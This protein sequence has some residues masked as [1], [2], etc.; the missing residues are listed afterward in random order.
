MTAIT[1]A[2]LI[3]SAAASIAGSAFGQSAK[4]TGG[5]EAEIYPTKPIRVVVPFG[6]GGTPD[7]L[8]RGIAEQLS[9][10]VGQPLIVDNRPGAGGNIGAGIVARANPDGYHL[11]MAP[12]SVLTINPSLYAQMPFDP[13]AAFAPISLVADMPNVLVVN[14]ANTAKS[15]RELIEAARR[16]PGTLFFSSPGQGTV[17][18]LAIELFQRAGGITVHHVPYKSGG[19]AVA[20]VLSGQVTGTFANLPLV[21]S[22]IRAGSL[23][24]LGIT[25]SSRLPQ[26]PDVPTISE[27]GVRGFEAS[28]WFGLVAPAKTPRALVDELSNQIAKALREPDVQARFAEIGV[29]LVGNSPEEFADYIRKDRAKWVE[30]IRSANVRLD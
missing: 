25:S 16:E 22:H 15:V 20:A 1:V 18:H 27:A 21:S 4:S 7:M 2:S 8:A 3:I 6:A 9:K 19:E 5:A 26:L 11:L 23:R 12:G 29:R 13:A 28:S 10:Q 24:A 17:P 30:V 14:P